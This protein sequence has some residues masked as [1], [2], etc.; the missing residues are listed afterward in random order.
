VY[1]R[2]RREQHLQNN[3]TVCDNVKHKISSL[4]VRHTSNIFLEKMFLILPNDV[5]FKC[6]YLEGVRNVEK[7]LNL[8]PKWKT[9]MSWS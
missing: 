9:S 4:F 5:L 8:L 1:K 6:N 3:V 7:T 2:K